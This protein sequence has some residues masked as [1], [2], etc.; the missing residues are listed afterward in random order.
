MAEVPV[1]VGRELV[2]VVETL[3]DAQD[4]PVDVLAVHLEDRQAKVGAV[5]RAVQVDLV[6][7]QCP[8]DV[9]DIVGILDGVV[10]VQI[11]AALA[12]VRGQSACALTLRVKEAVAGQYGVRVVARL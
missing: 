2:G 11:D 10:G 5:A 12:P 4:R 6:H 3:D 1:D 7:A 9:I 8:T